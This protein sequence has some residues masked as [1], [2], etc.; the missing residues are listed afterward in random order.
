MQW[1]SIVF[2]RCFALVFVAL[3][4]VGLLLPVMPTVP[5]LIAALWAASKGWP[6]LEAKLLSHPKYGPDILAWRERRCIRRNAKWA[7]TIMMAGGYI[8][9]WFMKFPPTY[10]KIIV[11][12]VLTTVA[13]W[14]WLR[15]EPQILPKTSG[16]A[17]EN[18][19]S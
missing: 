3:G 14:L 13:I 18:P 4:F 17:D 2:W 19:K 10:L 15:P 9:L 5:F 12:I 6:S 11:G 7:A 1:V 8:V 16:V